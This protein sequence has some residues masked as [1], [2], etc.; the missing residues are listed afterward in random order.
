MLAVDDL[1]V[2]A[3]G[4]GIEAEPER[5]VEDGGELDLL[6]APQ[7]RV[8][9]AAGGVLGDEVVHDV[10]GEPLGEVPDVERDPEDVGDPSRVEIEALEAKAAPPIPDQSV[11]LPTRIRS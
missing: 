3:G 8:G 9:R 7:A 11:G 10:L 2:V 1:R 4:D 6:V 5:A